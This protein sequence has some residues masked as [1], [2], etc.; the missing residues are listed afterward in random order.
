[1]IAGRFKT[2]D[3]RS[4]SKI[5]AKSWENVKDKEAWIPKEPPSRTHLS[6]RIS[7]LIKKMELINIPVFCILGGECARGSNHIPKLFGNSFASEFR[8][9]FINSGEDFYFHLKTQT[10]NVGT[11]PSSVPSFQGEIL[12]DDVNYDYL[13]KRV[14]SAL[15][16]KS[17]KNIYA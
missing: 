11:V 3:N 17:S 6:N 5:F 1:M 9:Y 13:K 7:V 14:S 15:L 16:Q 8:E 12:T 2:R 10:R 4:I